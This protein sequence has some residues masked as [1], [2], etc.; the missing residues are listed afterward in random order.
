MAESSKNFVITCFGGQIAG[1]QAG[2]SIFAKQ[3]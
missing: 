1:I 3:N 2:D